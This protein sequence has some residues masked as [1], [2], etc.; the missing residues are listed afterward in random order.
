MPEGDTVW[1]TAQRLHRALAGAPLLHADLR[2]GTLA[3]VDLR[4]ATTTEVVSRGKHLLQRLDDG[5]TL[6]SHLR[7]EGEWRIQRTAQRSSTGL[8]HH[9]IRAVIATHEW[10]VVGWR[11]GMLDLVPTA[12]EHT[13]VGHLGPDLLGPDWDRTRA[14][15]N[16]RTHPEVAIGAA[17]LDQ[18]NLAG[19][20]T[21]YAS[22]TLFAQ[23]QDPWQPVGE[24]SEARLLAMVE[25]ARRLLDA[26][27]AHAIPNTT[28]VPRRGE[29]V[30][31]HGRAGR[32]CRRCGGRVRVEPIGAA[33]RDRVMF[34]CP[35]CQAARRDPVGP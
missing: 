30:Y 10:T 17:L 7:M 22:E 13:L 16:L 28:G 25:R 33:P 1:R 29:Q 11:L 14:V 9:A 19:I 34:F 26:G 20:G 21:I 6:H 32:P 8:S 23:R 18:R 27:R 31:V 3:T 2:W 15:A 5:R 12:E 4:G 35:H 24:I